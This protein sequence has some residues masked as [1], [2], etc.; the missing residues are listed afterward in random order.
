M[1]VV[2]E[3]F[4][5]FICFVLGK[6]TQ[7][8]RFILPRVRE[9]DSKGVKK[10]LLQ[11]YLG[12]G[13]IL[14]SFPLIKALR[15]QYPNAK[16]IFLTVES[17]RDILELCR[18]ADQIL[19]IRLDSL[20]QFFIDSI[21]LIINL[22][23]QRIDISIDLE[24]FAKFP[25]IFSLF[26]FAKVRI[27]LYQRRLR[28]EGIL[29]HEVYYNPYRHISRIY[30]AYAEALGIERKNE[31]FTSLLPFLKDS[32][33]EK[34]RNKLNLKKDIPIV[35]INVNAGVLFYLRR[36]PAEYFVEII[37][38]LIS[39][40]P[41]YYYILM[42]DSVDYNYVNEIYKKLEG[43][44]QLINAAGKTTIAEL[45]ALI[46]MSYLMITSDSG[47]F[48]IA[49]LYGK[50]IA[51]FFGPETPLVYGPLRDNAL[52]FYQD[53]FHC[54]PCLSVYDNKRSYYGKTCKENKCLLKFKPQEVYSQIGERFFTSHL[55]SSLK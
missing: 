24:F 14:N 27:G 18:V 19:T 40:H 25:L 42:G 22:M 55:S 36:W 53:D 29:T 33:G 6:L 20:M 10:I 13:S 12:L 11:K 49:S 43:N 51:V 41:N 47:P 35:T 21:K 2:D 44:R 37:K 9:I 26:T 38:L 8:K 54:S 17:H 3:S 32:L 52:V 45:F 50:N 39:N 34:L 31:Y 48:H 1:R 46:D 16:I 5:M 30:F 7:L 4:G 23:R 15:K 28:P